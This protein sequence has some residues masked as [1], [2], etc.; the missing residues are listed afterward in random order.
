MTQHR[1]AAMLRPYG[2]VSRN[3]RIDEKVKRGFERSHFTE[4][5]NI[6]LGDSS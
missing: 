1:L 5:F 3:I 2:I 6:W 4:V